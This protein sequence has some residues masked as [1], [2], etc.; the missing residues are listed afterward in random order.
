[1][2]IF[3]LETNEDLVKAARKLTKKAPKNKY[4]AILYRDGVKYLQ[5]EKMS[6][7]SF[8]KSLENYIKSNPGRELYFGPIIK[9]KND[10]RTT[11]IRK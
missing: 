8:A 2:K 10:R 7:K 3:N 9:I 5:V 6:K 4:R 11:K 1:M